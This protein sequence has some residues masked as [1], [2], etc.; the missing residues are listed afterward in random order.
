MFDPALDIL[1]YDSGERQKADTGNCAHLTV[2]CAFGAVRRVTR[3]TAPNAHTTNRNSATSQ[4][5]F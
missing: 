4:Q 1:Y 3:R 5:Q 2:V